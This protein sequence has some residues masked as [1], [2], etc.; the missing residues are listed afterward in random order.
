MSDFE[1]KTSQDIISLATEGAP[2]PPPDMKKELLS[3]AFSYAII[4]VL[5]LAFALAINFFVIV[6]AS[7]PT[8]SMETTI[9]VNDR[10]IAFRL[11]YLFNEPERYDIIVFRA[12]DDGIKNVKRVIALPGESVSITGGI[13]YINGTAIVRD[14]FITP[15]PFDYMG[16][17]FPET[18]VP[19]GHFFMLGDSRGNSRDSRDWA[20]PF[21]EKSRIL[22]KVIFRYYPGF[23]NLT[24]S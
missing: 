7:I 17:D 9:R 18:L 13:V 14:D 23:R 22:G 19:E 16:P 5:A 12:P 6:N 3:E 15:G 21:V 4:V 24:N 1:P 8:G 20:N 11:S 2:D 10:I